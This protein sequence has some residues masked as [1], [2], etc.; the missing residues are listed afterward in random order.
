M[1]D[2][3]HTQNTEEYYR[4]EW[5]FSHTR[6]MTY[7]KIRLY[8]SGCWKFLQE[9]FGSGISHEWY[10]VKDANMSGYFAK[11]ELDSFKQ[12]VYKKFI[13]PIFLKEV[14]SVLPKRITDGFDEYLLS[15]SKLG[16]SVSKESTNDDVISILNKFYYYDR[17]ISVFFWIL[18]NDVEYTLGEAIK[19]FLT[20]N[21]VPV[22]E[23]SSIFHV[24]SEPIYPTP[25][26]MEL[27]SLHE[28][29]LSDIQV[30][31][32][33]LKKHIDLYC[34]MPMY[35]INYEPYS[36]KYFSERLLTL[37]DKGQEAIQKEKQF[38]ED[39]YAER[40]KVSKS[41]LTK[42]GSS[43]ELLI[44][45]EMF[46]SYSYLKDRKP[47]TR[48]KGGYFMRPVFVEISRRLGLS[49]DQV[50]FLNEEELE[51]SI[52]DGYTVIS[53]DILDMR[54]ND[55]LYFCKDDNI[56]V[57]TDAKELERFDKFILVKEK[58][59]E[60]KGVGVSKG[61]VS[62]RVSI[63]LSNNDFSKFEQ[64]DILVSSA[65]RP[66]FVPLMKKAAAILTDEGGLLSHAA[67]VSRELK[68]PCIVGLK[69]ST[70]VLKD[71]DMVE[72]DADNGIIKKL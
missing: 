63:I 48:D 46:V 45:L 37:L 3:K 52:R 43:E 14:V 8:N 1:K 47:Y 17:N 24:I 28:V 30:R 27:I 21:N 4:K 40:T 20:K 53:P 50:L 31:D 60:L 9:L 69:N 23:I 5:V 58:I 25:L 38:I 33:K 54:R 36:D 64:G 42:Y 56:T 49:L 18:F 57:I 16:Q 2:T 12:D 65:T 67:I 59:T 13:D 10:R 62:G 41:V 19:Y 26:D 15:V 61:K 34:Y 44:L 35:D 7:Q 51:A 39:K 72:V 6:Q 68:K 70:K 29:A 32:E 11:D 22:E 71:G 55:S 66:D